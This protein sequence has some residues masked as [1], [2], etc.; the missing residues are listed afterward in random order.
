MQ[1]DA[2]NLNIV[3]RLFTQKSKHQKHLNSAIVLK[4]TIV[5]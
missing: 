4:E 2:K 3:R 5:K 1:L